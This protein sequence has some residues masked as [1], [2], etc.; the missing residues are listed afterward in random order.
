[1]SGELA[2]LS[3]K[4]KTGRDGPVTIPDQPRIC[5]SMIELNTIEGRKRG[6]KGTNVELFPF[7]R[8]QSH[9]IEIRKE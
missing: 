8:S 3:K 1:M 6:K 7:R 4:K 2:N 5:Q 9:T